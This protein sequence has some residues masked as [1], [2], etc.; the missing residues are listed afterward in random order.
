MDPPRTTY[1]NSGV[2]VTSCER[3]APMRKPK[4]RFLGLES[5]ECRAL[6]S[7]AHLNA[8]VLAAT[9]EP[10][11][12]ITLAATPPSINENDALTLNGTLTAG[13][14]EAHD[15]TIQWGDGASSTLT[16]AAG[17]LTF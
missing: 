3:M 7:A 6:L 4:Q 2:V 8:A 15:L 10:V 12:T 9:I 1:S 5:L 13:L 11:P 17:Q 16:L 14:V